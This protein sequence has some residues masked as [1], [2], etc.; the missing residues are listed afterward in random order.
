MPVA[1]FSRLADGVLISESVDTNFDVLVPRPGVDEWELWLMH[2]SGADAYRS[3]AS[4][5]RFWAERHDSRPTPEAADRL[6]A[7]VPERG[8]VALNLLAEIGDPRAGDLACA[9]ITDPD[10]RE[11]SRRGAARPL[12]LLGESRFVPC[13]RRAYAMATMFDFRVEILTALERCGDPD[14]D[15]L[16]EEAVSDPDLGHIAQARL[17]E[18]RAG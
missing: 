12:G 9:Y 18:R 6:V 2:H 11:F 5:L 17:A 7:S 16:L 8:Q 15:A 1:C 4:F 10:V 13:L 3:F 14:L